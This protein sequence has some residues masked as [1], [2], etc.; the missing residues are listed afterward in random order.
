MEAEESRTRENQTEAALSGD[1]TRS[2]GL[3]IKATLFATNGFVT[4]G[5]G[6]EQM[7]Q[8]GSLK[9]PV[10]AQSLRLL[11][12]RITILRTCQARQCPTDL[13]RRTRSRTFGHATAQSS[14]MCR[15]AK[16]ERNLL[17]TKDH[18]MRLHTAAL[19]SSPTRGGTEN[20]SADYAGCVKARRKEGPSALRRSRGRNIRRW[21]TT[22]AVQHMLALSSNAV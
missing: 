10:V 12:G 19:T 14:A 7:I 21:G 22:V 16:T 5:I 2:A 11:M 6:F 17:T 15:P 18:S 3:P 4:Y 1:T 20:S 8:M 9:C 13:V